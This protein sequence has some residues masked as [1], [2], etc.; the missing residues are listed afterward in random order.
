MS[1]TARRL[2]GAISR[3]VDLENLIVLFTELEKA[4]DDFCVLNDEF[5]IGASGEEFSEHR[6]VNGVNMPDYEA[7]VKHVYE[8]ASMEFKKLK[9]ARL[10]NQKYIKFSL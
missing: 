10:E 4:Y 1:T 7:A 6:V 2:S 3:G 5:E 8:N 9:T